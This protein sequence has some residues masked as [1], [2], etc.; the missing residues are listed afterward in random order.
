MSSSGMVWVMKSLKA[1]SPF[2][3]CWMMPGNSLRPFTPPKAE[4]RHTRPV[5][6]WNG[7]VEISAPAGA[8]PM[9]TLSPQPLW[10]HSK[11]ARGQRQHDLIDPV[12]SALALG[13]DHRLERPITVSGH[14][15][16]DGPD[17][18]EHRLHASPVAHVLR[19][20]G[21]A[22]LMPEMLSQLR[23]Q[24][25]LEHVLRELAEQASRPGQAHALLFRLRE[26]ALR[27]FL[28][29]DDLPG[30]GINHRLVQQFGRV[31]HGHLL[32]DQAG[33]THR[34]SALPR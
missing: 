21:S 34:Y 13:D 29:I 32:S 1:N 26:Q 16:L 6:S 11:A 27:E 30:H 4:P 20:R 2:M 10:Q 24:R 8:T 22:V 5:T 19:D 25:G 12:Q 33:P 17:L 28:L 3:Y 14:L 7:R 15:D 18:R 23:V 31:S 9:I